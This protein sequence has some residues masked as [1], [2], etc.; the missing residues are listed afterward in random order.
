VS[1]SLVVLTPCRSVVSDIVTRW[2][3]GTGTTDSTLV[4]WRPF[5]PLTLAVVWYTQVFPT[6]MGYRGVPVTDELE[7]VAGVALGL[8]LAL[9]AMA[10]AVVPEATPELLADAP[11]PARATTAVPARTARADRNLLI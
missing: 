4:V 5:S 8:E 7:V 11:H 9:D 6:A 2:P 3:P 10:D 1:S